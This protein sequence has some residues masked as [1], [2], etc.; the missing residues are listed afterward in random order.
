MAAHPG[1]GRHRPGAVPGARSPVQPHAAMSDLYLTP[2]EQAMLAGEA[3]PG[4]RKAMEIVVAL[5]RIYGAT[6][7]VPVA[8]AH[9]AGVSYK[10]IGDAGIDFLREWAGQGAR[11]RVPATLNP[12][13]MER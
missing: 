9:I 8:H 11:A 4:V 6:D 7:L 13:G 5:G 10:N 3:G 12:M 2:E 1:D